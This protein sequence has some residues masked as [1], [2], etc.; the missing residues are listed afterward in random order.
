VVPL[1]EE[2]KTR[3]AGSDRTSATY[4][5]IVVA[6][7]EGWSR[8]MFGTLASSVTGAKSRIGSKGSRS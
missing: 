1:P 7:T 3:R 4:S 5:R 8:K 6:G 2:A